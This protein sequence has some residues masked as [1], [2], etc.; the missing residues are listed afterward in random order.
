MWQLMGSLIGGETA[1][2]VLSP[3]RSRI[4]RMKRVLAYIR[5]RYENTITLAELASLA[6][7][8]PKYF[9]RA[10]SQMT[11]KTPIEYLNY[12]RVEQAGEQLLLTDRSITDIALGCGFNDMSYFSKTFFRYKGMSPSAYRKKAV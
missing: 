5:D 9:C 4:V 3:N 6:G 11:G 10:F 8:T 1:S 12:Y 2:T 7:M